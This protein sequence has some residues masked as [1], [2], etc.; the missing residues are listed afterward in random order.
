MRALAILALAT[1]AIAADIPRNATEGV[2]VV[3]LDEFG[4]EIHKRISE[5][6]HS[7]P[8]ARSLLD[9]DDELYGRDDWLANEN[10]PTYS[11]YCG[12]GFK[13]NTKD[14][15]A[16]VADLR[17]QAGFG[18]WYPHTAMYSVRGSTVAFM[19]KRGDGKGWGSSSHIGK[20]LKQAT[21]ACG[22][23]VPG[24]A[25]QNQGNDGTTTS[26]IGIMRWYAGLDFCGKAEG[27]G[28]HSC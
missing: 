11:T 14:T 7:A 21:S 17:K 10:T 28:D 27:A 19:C 23:Y 2:Y 15:D 20:L 8:E 26:N 25:H 4:N 12:C 9:G 16:A 5:P 6:L 13:L 24:T 22:S 3:A 18:T 1:S